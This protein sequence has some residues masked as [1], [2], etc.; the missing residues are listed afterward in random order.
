MKAYQHTNRVKDH[1]RLKSGHKTRLW[2]S[3]DEGRKK[4]SKKSQNVGVKNHDTLG[5][6]CYPCHSRLII[7]CRKTTD[8]VTKVAVHLDHHAKHVHYVDVSMPPGALDIV[9]ENVEWLTPVTMVAKVLEYRK[10]TRLGIEPRPSGHIPDALTTELSSLVG[11]N[12]TMNLMYLPPQI[13]VTSHP[14]RTIQSTIDHQGQPNDDSA[15]T[16]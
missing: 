16:T 14:Q 3:Q 11:F 5:M 7:S 12:P 10:V 9:R 13:M 4:K 15:T 6:K 8:G 2:C 1:K